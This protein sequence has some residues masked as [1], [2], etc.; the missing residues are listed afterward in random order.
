MQSL[1]FL[2]NPDIPPIE[3]ITHDYNDDD[4]YYL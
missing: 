1:Y 3:S 2:Y 4:T